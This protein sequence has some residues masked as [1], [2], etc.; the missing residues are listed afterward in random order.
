M[1]GKACRNDETGNGFGSVDHRQ[2]VGCEVDQAAPGA[3]YRRVARDRQH[4]C[5][6]ID[7]ITDD[8]V[9]WRG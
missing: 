9:R 4:M 1:S 5:D 3:R 6:Q 2:R 8:V 7:R